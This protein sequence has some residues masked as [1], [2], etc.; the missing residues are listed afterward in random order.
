MNCYKGGQHGTRYGD[1]SWLNEQID[2][3]PIM[4]QNKVRA[5]YSEIYQELENTDPK[6]GRYRANTWMRSIVKKHG[7]VVDKNDLMF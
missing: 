1:E 5:R 2:L 7:L 6:N 3:L 4:M